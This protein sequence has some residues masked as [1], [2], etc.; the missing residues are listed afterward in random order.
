MKKTILLPL[1]FTEAN[2]RECGER[3]RQLGALRDLYSDTAEF[4]PEKP[5]GAP[6]P[7]EADGALFPQMIGAIFSHRA[8]LEKLS[9]PVIVLT[10]SFGTVEMWD[11]EIVS[12]LRVQ[13][14]LNVFTP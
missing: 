3:Q 7:P 14:G 11:W 5:L 6:I 2:E 4:L 9:L 1:Y 12:Y 13:M 8:E 10:S